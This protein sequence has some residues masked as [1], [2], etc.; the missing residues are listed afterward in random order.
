MQLWAFSDEKNLYLVFFQ[1]L[2]PVYACG[3]EYTVNTIAHMV[4]S[5]VLINACGA[6]AQSNKSA[7]HLNP[8]ITWPTPTNT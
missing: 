1:H 7:V 6:Q 3:D 5:Q 8:L 2:Y 4:S